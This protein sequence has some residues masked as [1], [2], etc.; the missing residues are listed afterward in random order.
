MKKYL[1]VAIFVLAL[2]SLFAQQTPQLTLRMFDPLVYNPA[3]AGSNKYPEVKMHHRNQW[4]GFAGA[5][6]TS[7]VSYHNELSTDMGFGGYILNDIT[8]PSRRTSVN[9]CYAYHL[10]LPYF[11]WAFGLAGSFMQYSLNGKDFL[12][13]DKNDASLIADN[14]DR[15]YTPDA[16][17]G[18]YLYNSEFFFGL[19]AMQLISSKLN[20]YNDQSINTSVQLSKHYYLTAGY[21]FKIDRKVNFEPSILLNKVNGSPYQVDLNFKFDMRKRYVFA[22]N[23]RHKDAVSAMVG[24]RF[25]RY[26]FAY[27]FDV[28][29]TRLI[30]VNAGSH[31]VVFA[32]NWPFTPDTKPMY[33]LKGFDRGQIRKRFVN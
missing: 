33:D 1:F 22:L 29:T 32:F 26:F 10:K 14:I 24:Y 15:R 25:K 5:P 21:T 6:I 9:L 23:Y 30:N 18:M 17:F 28:A 16:T 27:S 4:V 19:S 2:S 7:L 13:K 8:G 12:Y 31:E 11:Y 20:F 3:V